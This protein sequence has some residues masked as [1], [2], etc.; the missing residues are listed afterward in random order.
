MYHCHNL[1][2]YATSYKWPGRYGHAPTAAN[3][4]QARPTHT[5]STIHSLALCPASCPGSPSPFYREPGH[6]AII[7]IYI[8][9]TGHG[10]ALGYIIASSPGHSQFFQCCTHAT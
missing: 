3:A 8:V 9:M 4:M 2:Y 5:L 1:N 6:E 7:I 10:Q